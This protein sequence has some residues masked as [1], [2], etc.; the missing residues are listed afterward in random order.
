M[1]FFFSFVAFELNNDWK[2]YGCSEQGFLKYELEPPYGGEMKNV[3]HLSLKE[4]EEFAELLNVI[5]IKSSNF[6]KSRWYGFLLEIKTEFQAISET[7]LNTLITFHTTCLL[8]NVFIVRDCN[9]KISINSGK[10]WLS[11]I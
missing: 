7:V 9:I 2:F 6:F 5:G 8:A 1:S 11:N 10:R 3:D 4:L